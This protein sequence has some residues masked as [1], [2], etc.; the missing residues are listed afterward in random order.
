MED[1]FEEFWRRRPLCFQESLAVNAQKPREG[2][3]GDVF[4]QLEWQRPRFTFRMS[5]IVLVAVLGTMCNVCVCSVAQLCLTLC[6]PMDYRL[7]G[8]FVRGILHARMLEWVAISFSRGSS[9]PRDQTQ[10]SC[11][12]VR[13]FTM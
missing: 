4:T 5:L 1:G 8:S 3:F 9:Q 11:I 12:A 13:H 7:P 10:V 6:D 2:C